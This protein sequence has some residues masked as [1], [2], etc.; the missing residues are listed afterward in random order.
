M[1]DSANNIVISISNGVDS[2]IA[3]KL[4]EIADASERAEKSVG[5]LK[6]QL[7]SM[8]SG[9][10]G[11]LRSQLESVQGTIGRTAS[12]SHNLTN[13]F[14]AAQGA[15]RLL[16]GQLPTRAFE[17]FIATSET[18]SSVLLAAFPIIGAIALGE[19]L[20]RVGSG[21]YR[22]IET[23]R[24]AGTAI[25]KAFDSVINPIR[26]SNDQLALTNDRLDSTIAK[27]SHRPSTNGAQTAIDEIRASADRLDESLEHVNTSLDGILKKNS[28][29]LWQSILTWQAPTGDT[30]KFVQAQ[31]DRITT[32]QEDARDKM[33]AASQMKDPKASANALREAYENERA[34]LQVA[35]D[36]LRDKYNVLQQAQSVHNY[37]GMVADE[38]ANLTMT[39]KA[40]HLAL[41][42][43]RELDLTY[44][45]IGKEAT[46]AKL[47]DSTSELKSETKQAAE[48][49]KKLESDFVKFQS[50]VDK[51]GHK[52]TAQQNLDWLVGRESTI[53]PLNRD[54]LSAKELPYQ[55]QIASQDF[56]NDQVNRLKD[57]V[58]QIGLYDNALKESSELD[59]IKEEAQ[60]RNITLTT[61]QVDTLKQ[62]VATSVES[63]AYD[64][65]LGTIYKSVNE[66]A[67][68][69]AAQVQA[70]NTL[71]Q[72]GA[73]D[74]AQYNQ[75]IDQTE[76]LYNEATSAVT[77]FKNEIA[78]AQRD[79]TNKLGTQRQIGVNTTLQGLDEQLRKP[80]ADSEH[81]FGYSESEIARINS[82]L[83]PLIDAMQRKNAVDQETNKLLNQQDDLM[84][85]L[86]INETARTKAL[87]AGA[88][89][90][91][92]A[93]AGRLRDRATLND[94]QLASGV[95]GNPFA[96]SIM[97]YA[98]QFQGVA[99]EIENAF[100]PVFKT[101]SD[102]FADSLG[103]A[104]VYGKN[105]GSALKDVARSALSEIISGLAKLG[106][107]EVIN[108]TMGTAAATAATA[109]GVAQA[110]TLASAWAPAAFAA[111][112]AS[113][114]AADAIGGAA[115]VSGL[116]SAI[117]LSAIPK[118]DVG[119]NSVPNDMLAF[120][121]QDERII[122]AADNR[123]LMDTLHN[124]TAPQSTPMH[125]EIHN[126]GSNLVSVQQ[127]TD[128][129]MRVMI[130]E[131]VP[132]LIAQHAPGVIANDITNPNSKTSKAITRNTYTSRRR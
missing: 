71:Y 115:Y 99:K 108:L 15:S 16:A 52:P 35:A 41:E 46:V 12:S 100:T 44:Q 30:A 116:A 53:N 13:A 83:S 110:T 88:I 26:R 91:S 45:N 66:P 114:G 125:V 105:L 28:L 10:I 82:E 32:A 63:Q 87:N 127:L 7:E 61:E 65:E 57:Q 1:A 9:G 93:N 131:R 76:K 117:A 118:F 126:N 64:R 34:L 89:S 31:F 20:Y 77:R 11:S 19:I 85:Q 68:T 97:D 70:L 42:E 120:V 81:P 59:R 119:T 103:R 4:I 14:Y 25:S 92:V 21:L 107:Q 75:S 130:D 54:R 98:K 40:A 96:G 73:I 101:L 123:E 102:G 72:R 22:T 128:N 122:P 27:L 18:L 43:I 80:G 111:S 51:T 39:G 29:N 104:I 2:N 56:Y 36:N 121:H 67:Q 17:R 94:S 47:R 49:W 90:Q 38:T 74:N 112:V 78:D 24:G 55:N 132:S 124:A 106:I 5:S 33:S 3:P 50:D 95:G 23:A 129:R 79:A 6:A 113:F 37:N 58:A 109:A 69:L 62:L 84:N 8:G 86:S 48:E 60:R